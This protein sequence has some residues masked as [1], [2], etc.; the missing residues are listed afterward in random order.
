MT[1]HNFLTG[2]GIISIFILHRHKWCQ[3]LSHQIYAIWGHCWVRILRIFKYQS[4]SLLWISHQ[5]CVVHIQRDISR[6]SIFLS[7][8]FNPFL[9][10]QTLSC[11]VFNLWNCA[12]MR[13][14]FLKLPLSNLVNLE[15]TLSWFFMLLLHAIFISCH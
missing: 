14:I 4:D 6:I 3:I 13:I 10:I 15:L 9:G 11:D 12:K 8:I 1:C 5:F 7:L 2:C